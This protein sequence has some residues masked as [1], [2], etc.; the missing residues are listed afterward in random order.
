MDENHSSG[1]SFDCFCEQLSHMDEDL[2]HGSA[3]KDICID[4]FISSVQINYKKRFFPESG[5]SHSDKPDH[6]C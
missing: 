1:T 6:I 3:G 4:H 2:I 5:K